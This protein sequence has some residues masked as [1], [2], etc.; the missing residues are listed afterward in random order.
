MIHHITIPEPSQ[1]LRLQRDRFGRSNHSMNFNGAAGITADNAPQL[2][3][4]LA[5][6]SFWVNPNTL[7]ASGEAYLLSFGGWQERWKISLPSHGKAVWTTHAT[8]CCSD[9]DAGDANALVPGTWTHMVMVHDGVKDYI[10]VNGV[11]ANSKD[12]PGDL[13]TTVHPLGIGFDPIDVA[14]YFDGCNG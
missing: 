5:S 2:N 12:S 8:S 14:N 7:P 10:Y 9:L 11:L 13:N 3:S 1:V 4:P 6:V